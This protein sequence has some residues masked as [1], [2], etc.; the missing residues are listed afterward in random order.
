MS[1]TLGSAGAR[2][3]CHAAVSP[4]SGTVPA[5]APWAAAAALIVLCALHGAHMVLGLALPPDV[6]ALRDIGFAQG[7]LD[8]DLFGDP[9]YAG[10]RRFYPPLIPA[11]RALV[12]RLVGGEDLP[13]HWVLLAPWLNLLA[14]LAF[15]FMTRRLFASTGIAAA[16]LAAYVLLN[17]AVS[18]PWVTG[19]YTP[20]PA[21]PTLAQAMFFA[22]VWLIHARVG[23][24]RWRDAAVLGAAIGLT[25]LAHVVPAVI[26]T[27]IVTAAAFV[28]QG[29]HPRT[30]L[31]LATVAAAQLAVMAP[32]ML[33]VLV[34]YPGGTVHTS[35][36]WVH[37][38]F[39]PMI[40]SLAK[41]LA[42]NAPGLAAAALVLGPLRRAVPPMARLTAV[43]V[44]AWV[45]VAGAFL[46]RHYACG[47]LAPGGGDAAPA[48]CR[49]FVVAIHH[50]HLYL[51]AAWPLL[52]GFAGW[53]LVRRWIAGAPPD[54][55][56]GDG[57]SRRAGVAA[58][59]VLA[60]LALGGAG[61]LLR[62]FDLESRGIALHHADRD[63]MD[64]AAYR[65]L[66]A[67]TR[68]EA[69]F[70]TEMLEP[71]RAPAAFS[72][73]AAGRKLISS[74][75]WFSHPYVDWATREEL[76]LRYLAALT[77]TAEAEAIPCDVAARGLWAL[78][79][80]GT[81]VAE[82]RAEPVFR[83][84]AHTVWRALPVAGCDAPGRV[85]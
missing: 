18:R 59:L 65:W 38:L 1:P 61:L 58:A 13:R 75:E 30:V 34:N 7:F 62:P 21:V 25:F 14:P 78:L 28:A 84:P 2:D 46:L 80:N 73:I 31:W 45:G 69:L 33:P 10:E 68:P 19:G 47:A 50:Y 54:G 57:R 49:A 79:P 42:L 51:Y 72:V 16:A 12:F 35:Y 39:K 11:L 56:Q 22:A 23:L 48:T 52:I 70:V 6:D 40:Q 64:L 63:A 24:A 66:L 3:G 27:G 5:W 8:G 17:G 74:P 32:Y 82:G 60:S 83:S 81:A 71:W 53:H 15:F 55:G 37:N 36:E 29:F 9:T 41:L 44:A 85:A 43:I 76:R 67:E 26:L 77:G 4:L 20:W